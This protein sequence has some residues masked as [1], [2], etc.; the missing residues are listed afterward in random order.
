LS[1][2]AKCYDL[3]GKR[4]IAKEYYYKSI[5]QLQADKKERLI[6]FVVS[7]YLKESYKK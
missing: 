2:I 6:D 1:F 5:I 3:E 7:P 4:D